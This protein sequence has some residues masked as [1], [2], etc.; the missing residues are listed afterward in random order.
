M[1][2]RRN[3]DT[4]KTR[5]PEREFGSITTRLSSPTWVRAASITENS[6][7]L[8]VTLLRHS[9]AGNSTNWGNV[10]AFVRAMDP[11]AAKVDLGG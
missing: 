6:A 4:H 8:V 1:A 7:L 9:G 11:K 10:E 3:L 2:A 5:R